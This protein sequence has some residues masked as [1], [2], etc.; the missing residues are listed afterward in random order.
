M[1]P[2][3]TF[4]HPLTEWAL[5]QFDGPRAHD[6]V[7]LSLA[8][9]A[10]SSPPVGPKAYKTVAFDILSNLAFHGHV[11][12]DAAGWYHRTSDAR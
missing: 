1:K 7:S 11:R 8:M 5:S 10:P 4:T 9:G 3:E 2:R 6:A 12:K